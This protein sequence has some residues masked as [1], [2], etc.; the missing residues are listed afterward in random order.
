MWEDLF[1]VYIGDL[2]HPLCTKFDFDFRFFLDL[3]GFAFIRLVDSR[4]DFQICVKRNQVLFVFAGVK[5][6]R[7]ISL[8]VFGSLQNA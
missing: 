1:L 3:I 7:T 6:D 5:M 2:P 4:L 8:R